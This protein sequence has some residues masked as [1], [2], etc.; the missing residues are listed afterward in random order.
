MCHF[1][2]GKGSRGSVFSSALVLGKSK[3]LRRKKLKRVRA[4][5]LPE[6]SGAS[7]TQSVSL[8]S[9]MLAGLAWAQ[10]RAVGSPRSSS[11]EPPE[12]PPCASPS[13]LPWACSPQPS[14]GAGSWRRKKGLPALSVFTDEKQLVKDVAC[15]TASAHEAFSVYV[16]FPQTTFSS[17]GFIPVWRLFTTKNE[18]QAP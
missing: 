17:F 11:V 8:S 14:P 5:S 4:P 15:F 9:A 1:P 10:E 13:R 6:K 12:A 2:G 7:W 16:F 18:I 3:Q